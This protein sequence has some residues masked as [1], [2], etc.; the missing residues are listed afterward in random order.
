MIRASVIVP[1]RAGEVSLPAVLA[2]ILDAAAAAAVDGLDEVVIVTDGGVLRPP[3]PTPA[4]GLAL[5]E[6]TN[7]RPGKFAALGAGVAAAAGESLVLVDAD[8]VPSRGAFSEVLRPLS[9]GVAE[10]CAGHLRVA[11]R[12]G[13]GPTAGLL[14]HWAGISWEAWHRHRMVA[15]AWCWALPGGLYAIRRDVFPAEVLCPA[16]D[17]ASIGLQ[18]L[19]AGGRFAYAPQALAHVLA[20]STYEDWLRQKLRSRLGWAV[21]ARERPQ[22]VAALRREFRR[23]L[24]DVTQGDRT[25]WLLSAQDH[26]LRGAARA[27]VRLGATPRARWKPAA[28][29]KEWLPSTA[30]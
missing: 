15:G 12:P 3:L 1:A 14:E 30:R 21:L 5:R 27:A 20:P 2:A 23:H 13:I 24:R 25:A 29:T 18:V 9:E 17:D 10:A 8:V 7:D 11:A 6:V 26:C 16:V 22:E 28:S 4:E 19:D